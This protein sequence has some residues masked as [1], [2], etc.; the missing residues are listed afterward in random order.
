MDIQPLFWRPQ[1]SRGLHD[2]LYFKINPMVD[3][4]IIIWHGTAL[5]LNQDCGWR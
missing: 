1:I 4:L 3:P 5:T 2:E